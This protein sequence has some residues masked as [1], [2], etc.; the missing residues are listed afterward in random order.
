MKQKSTDELNALL[1]NIKPDQLE[2]YI[3]ENRQY[4]ADDQKEFYY[5]VKD[6]LDKKRIKLKDVYLAAGISE[7]FGGKIIRMEKHAADR[8][9]IIKL[10]LAGRFNWKETN[11]A[12]KLYGMCELYSKDPRDA[13]I[14]VAI[15]NRIYNVYDIDAML[16]ERKL[17]GLVK[18]MPS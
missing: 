17:K 5:Y 13:C 11:R 4:L 10:C 7:S 15:N 14:I 3:K 2:K 18:T 8:D 9:M 16:R 12:L 6:I 1:Q